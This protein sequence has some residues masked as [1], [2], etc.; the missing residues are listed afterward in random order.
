M[1]EFEGAE[2]YSDSEHDTDEELKEAFAAG[3]L[4]PGLNVVGEIPQKKVA[5]NNISVLKQKY[6]ELKKTSSWVERLDMVNAPA[7]IAPELAYKEDQHGKQRQKQLKI[8]QDKTL[9]EDDLV[10]NDFKREMLFY[11]Q[12]QSAVLE[13]IARLKSMNIP[14]KRPE[15]YFAQMAKTD[16][17]MQKIRQKLLSKQQVQEKIEKVKKLRELKKY[18]KKVQVEVHQNRL[19]EKKQLMD[20]VKKFK[21]GKSDN[22]DFLDDKPG[23]VKP[24]DKRV[25][26]KRKSKDE[27]FGFGGKKRGSKRNTKDTTNDV[28]DF[29]LKQSQSRGRSEGSSDYS[30]S[31]SPGGGRAAPP[32]P[33]G[34]PPPRK[35]R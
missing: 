9:I 17:H 14:T 20:N 8:D 32:P 19:K 15:D 34:S 21:K 7:P 28:S 16:D 30:P 10:H 18:G 23:K 33:R 4:K 29:R 13:G 2:M 25:N 26:A 27:K 35:R 5:K 22:L 3:L 24:S 12:A 1:T 31:P 6:E 11:R